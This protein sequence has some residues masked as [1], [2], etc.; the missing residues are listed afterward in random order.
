MTG[1]KRHLEEKLL[2]YYRLLSA[3]SV[4]GSRQRGK[5]TPVKNLLPD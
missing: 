1:I 5:S 3:V 2:S 4:I